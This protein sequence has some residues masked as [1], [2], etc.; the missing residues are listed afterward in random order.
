MSWQNLT[1]CCCAI[2]T[3]AC[4]L[5]GCSRD[6]G[7]TL[8]PAEKAA[9]EGQEF[10]FNEDAPKAIEAYSRAIELNGNQPA[11]YL[12]RGTAY[13][14]GLQY[15]AAIADFTR[16]IELD[17]NMMG[18]YTHRGKVYELLGDPQKAK[19]DLETADRL[20]QTR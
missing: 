17:P 14:L 20:G 13:E 3:I 15:P 18:A 10:L 2:A 11:Y 9:L 12:N 5:L 1:T 19:A 4:C 6:P 7:V 8:S 16:A